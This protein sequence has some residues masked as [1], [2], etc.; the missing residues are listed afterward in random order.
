MSKKIDRKKMRQD[1]YGETKHSHDTKDDS[2]RFKDIFT[3]SL[4][5][6]CQKWKTGEGDHI[7][8][9][10]PWQ[11]GDFLDRSV[12]QPKVKKGDWVYRCETYVHG[13]IGP[14]QV[15]EICPAMIFEE[16]CPI[17]ELRSI[18]FDMDELTDHQQKIL[19]KNRPIRR[20]AYNIYVKD[21]QKEMDKGVQLWL[22]AH[23][24]F[25]NHIAELAQLPHGGGFLNFSDVDEGKSI[26][27]KRKGT[28]KDNT[29][30]IG[31]RFLDRDPLEDDLLLK[32]HPVDSLIRIPTYEDLFRKFFQVE[33]KG[34]PVTLALI[35]GKM[36]EG[37]ESESKQ[38]A[39][40]DGPSEESDVPDF[41]P[42]PETEKKEES[43]GEGDDRCP[44]GHQFGADLEKFPSDCG[45]CA[46]WDDCADES[47]KLKKEGKGERPKLN[48]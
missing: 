2:G 33:Y 18:L 11:A 44:H 12:L 19:D 31:H 34:Q 8:D 46:V 43:S 32:A 24:F 27:F 30:F 14:A 40:P 42:P 29:S 48:I 41:D 22:I 26:M 28:G 16:P 7:V 3:D 9:L 1:L 25:E 17:C 39:L 6:G 21:S 35:S 45:Q 37:D 13:R 38:P 23:F 5:D 4:P 47:D 15:D 20:V 36:E 10:I